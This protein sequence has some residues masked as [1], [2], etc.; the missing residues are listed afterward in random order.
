MDRP[1][2]QVLTC[3]STMREGEVMC[4]ACWQAV[5]KSTRNAIARAK[6]PAKAG[7]IRSA[8]AQAQMAPRS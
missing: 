8:L 1:Q 5:P 4:T 7:H 6:G 3:N 2:C